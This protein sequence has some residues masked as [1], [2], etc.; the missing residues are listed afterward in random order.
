MKKLLMLSFIFTLLTGCAT[1][2]YYIHGDR[3]A[4]P[5]EKQ[6]QAFFVSGI[7]QEQEMDAAEI[8][9]GAHN[10][11]KVQSKLNFLDGFLGV[12]SW[13]IYTPRTA[14]VYCVE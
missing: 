14:M 11:A 10:V 4:L 8:C 7:G 6:L 5:D 1:Q 13:G 9:G 12:I 2:T 3:D